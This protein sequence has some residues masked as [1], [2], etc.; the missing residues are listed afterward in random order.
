MR[1]F[2]VLLLVV[3]ALAAAGAAGATTPLP[4]FRTANG[5][6]SCVLLSVP[7]GNL[8]CT[9]AHAR[10]AKTLQNRCMNP[11]GDKGAG[12]DWHGFLLP[13]RTKARINCSGGILYDPSR[14]HYVTIGYGKTWGLAGFY[15]TSHVSGLT[16]R[17]VR[18]HG[19]LISS[20]TDRT[21]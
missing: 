3:L 11:N 19:F 10:Y 6:I 14:V 5:N 8:L 4:G 17:N 15:C 2:C 21:W 1:R 16:C 7:T 18:G 12:V 20:R 13:P 9:I